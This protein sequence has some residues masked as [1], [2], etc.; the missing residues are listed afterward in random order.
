MA[1]PAR[2][3]E[4]PSSTRVEQ[5]EALLRERKLDR[6]LTTTLP[7][8]TGTDHVAGFGL[9]VLDARLA[10]VPRGQVSELVGSTSSG[11]TS[12]AWTW[13]GA[14]TTR[15]E[16]V[17]LIDTF[18]RFDPA[19]GAACG[20][21]LS[22]LLWVRGQAI[23]KTASAVDPAWL[24]G[25]RAVEGPGTLLER[26]IDRSLKALNLVLQSGVC[27]AVVLDFAD[28]PLT[29]IR[30]V[31][32]TTWLR[33]QRIVEGTD[34]ACLLLGPI[35]LARSAG[36]VTITTGD[37]GGTGAA[38][39]LSAADTAGSSDVVRSAKS[40][41]HSAKWVGEHDRSRR[42]AGLHVSMRLSS[43]RR[44][45]HGSVALDTVTRQDVWVIE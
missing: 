21:E 13:L 22:R 18:D 10:G 8:R 9:P 4:T 43:P 7:A 41:G 3:A 45:V 32:Q 17:A 26:T 19:S 42:L 37:T 15:G 40:D 29:G 23:T 31:P 38:G 16:S 24:P 14:A 35:L 33:L 30:R 39:V 6:T 34:V 1:F 2:Q 28:V 36:G 44:T 11:R 20:I 25:A 12:L 5:V 27:T